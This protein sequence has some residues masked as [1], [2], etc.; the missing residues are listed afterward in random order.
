M[1]KEITTPKNIPEFIDVLVD[2]MED[3]IDDYKGTRVKLSPSDVKRYKLTGRILEL[4]SWVECLKDLRKEYESDIDF[5][6][7]RNTVID[8]FVKALIPRLT[9]AI[10]QKDV[11]SM[12][13]LIND[14]ARELK[15]GCKNE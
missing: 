15:V 8:E 5:N 12:T 9:D 11:E 2:D 6:N 10:Y 3:Y 13:N 1:I 14:V 7:I 4:A